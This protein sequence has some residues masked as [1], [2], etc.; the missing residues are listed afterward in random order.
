MTD[1]DTAQIRDAFER[2]L[3]SYHAPP[4]L[5]ERARSGGLRRA[6]HRRLEASAG[7][8]AAAGAAA[9][10]VTAWPTGGT[11]AATAAPFT[12]TQGPRGTIVINSR[13]FLT[14]AQ[15][16][17]LQRQ[18]RAEGVP[19]NVS[20]GNG[21]QLGGQHCQMTGYPYPRGMWSRVF[22]SSR[23]EHGRVVLVIHPAALSPGTGILLS[24]G[25]TTVYVQKPGGPA[26]KRTEPNSLGW[27]FV[28]AS[29]H[30]T[31]T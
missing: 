15:G 23:T 26:R 8:A 12:V 29:P 14:K 7:L 18:L 4:G 1:L 22:I 6:R 3:A 25:P 13:E 19:V 9:I 2:D 27:G 16:A 17:Q 31:G 21:N 5:A 10:A 24:G 20:A 11:P 30:C 28:K